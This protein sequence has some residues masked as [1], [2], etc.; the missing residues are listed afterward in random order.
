MQAAETRAA[1]AAVD[2]E[3]AIV[4]AGIRRVARPPRRE[5]LHVTLTGE[6]AWSE[7]A[8]ADPAWERVDTFR[9]LPMQA[10][11]LP[12]S[13][14]DWYAVERYLEQ[15]P[16]SSVAVAYSAWRRAERQLAHAR[17]AEA[18][19]RPRSQPRPAGNFT[20]LARLVMQE[21]HMEHHQCNT[22]RAPTAPACCSGTTTRRARTIRATAAAS[23][24]LA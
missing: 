12:V 13:G 9:D 7:M 24:L 3:R 4:A 16:G 23:S 11:A 5:Y 22:A 15:W 18:L 20:Q 6:H 21:R 2:L 1:Q 19:A 14:A 17:R 8:M 10:S